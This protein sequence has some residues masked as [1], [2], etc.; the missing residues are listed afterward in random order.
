MSATGR[1]DEEL[2]RILKEAAGLNNGDRELAAGEIAA[3]AAEVRT[4]GDSRHGGEI[5][6]RAELGCTACHSVNGQGG[7]I[8]PD[9]SG[10]GASAP[11]DF[12]IESVLY[13]NKVVKEGYMS[14]SVTTRDGEEYQG[15]QVRESKDELVLRDTLRNQEVR[16][17]RG[18]ILEKKQI[19]S[20]MPSGLVA[21]LTRA[22][23]R[24]LIRYLADLGRTKP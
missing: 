22:E 19:G 20:I 1:R 16:V 6:H 10:I 9:L 23:F 7:N 17:R 13:P 3:F 4:A 8:G 14:I 21:S 11:P 12:I 24:D 2:A 5:F 18:A 15:F